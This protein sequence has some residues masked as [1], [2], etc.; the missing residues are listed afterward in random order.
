MLTYIE[1][2]KRSYPNLKVNNVKLINKGQN[3]DVFI[4]NEK[5]IFRFPK[6]Q[7]GIDSLLTEVELL[8]RIN[9]HL[10]L[11]IPNPFFYSLDINEVGSTFVGYKMIKGKALWR[12]RFIDIKDKNKIAEQLAEF[13]YELHSKEVKIKASE[14]ISKSDIYSKWLNLYKRIK[15]KLFMYMRDD[16]KRKVENNFKKFLSDFNN[17]FD[18]VFV[19]GDFGPSNILFDEK[20]ESISGIIDFG[21]SHIGDPAGDFA[22]LIGPFGY[23]EDFILKFKKIYPKVDKYIKRAKFYASTFALQEALFGIEN[24]DEKA[25]IN[26]IEQYK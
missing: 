26:G 25:F 8:K 6:Y 9:T 14:L 5:Y 19:H 12:E 24:N 21:E 4:I 2:I 20:K 15:E 16:A 11:D 18:Y 10:T 22:S 3:N 13:L 1:N 23:G 7:D 17:D